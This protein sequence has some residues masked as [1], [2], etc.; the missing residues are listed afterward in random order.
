MKLQEVCQRRSVGR[1][2]SAGGYTI[3]SS[4]RYLVPMSEPIHLFSPITL[5]GVTA[6]NRVF[7]SPMCQYSS[8]DG[9]VDDWHLVHLGSRA[10]GGAGLVM[11]EA[12]A[13][14]PEGRISYADLGIWS[15]EHVDRLRRVTAFIAEHGAVPAIQLAHAGRKASTAPPWEG[16]DALEAP[17]RRWEPVAPTDRPFSDVSP[18]PRRLSTTEVHELVDAFAAAAAR[19]LMAG[20]HAIEIHGAHGYLVHE[21]LSPLAN[22]RDDEYG[23]DFEGRTRFLM[24]IVAAV[25]AAIGEE[26]PL[27]VRLSATDWHDEGWKLDDSVELARRLAAAGVD[28]VDCSSAGIAPSVPVPVG[29]GYQ[30]HL[31]AAVRAGAGI[32]SGAVGLITSPQQADHIV[33]SGQADVMLLARELLRDPYWPHRAAKALGVEAAAPAQ[34]R[35]AL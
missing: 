15:D 10:V 28:L 25:R 4:R 26:V 22:D 11:S 2:E 6:R 27:L 3:P 17:G 31:A 32:A 20:F 12:A 16:P 7:V 24:E 8:E 21:F 34:Y 30:T 1:I 13:V 9:F 23:G 35:R 18:V 14:T 19:S 5:R 29:T 33:R